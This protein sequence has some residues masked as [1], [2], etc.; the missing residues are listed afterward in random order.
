MKKTTSVLSI[1][2]A[3]LMVFSVTSAAADALTLSS[4]TAGS[5]D[6]LATENPQI[7]ASDSIV[8]TFSNNVTDDSVIGNNI[9]KINVKD[10]DGNKLSTVSVSA[11]TDK[12]QLAVS[13]GE[14][15]KGSY[16]LTVAKGIKAKNGSELADKTEIKFTV[17]KGSGDGS[18]G[19]NN[20]LSFV[21]A[22][23]NDKELKGAELAGNEIIVIEFDRGMKTYEEDNAKAIGIYKADN[24]K[25]DYT[26]LPV[27]KDQ[28]ETK[29]LVK[30]QLN[31]L[32]SG[33]YTLKIGADVK[34]NNG[35]T[36][37]E[38]VTVAFTVKAAE[39]SLLDTIIEYLK[40]AVEFVRN[41]ITQVVALF[42]SAQ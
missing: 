42:K 1:I 14:I 25:A 9:G 10:S 20:P 28:E 33:E 7:G 30:I 6:L 39:K 41:I 34:A 36:L 35:N 24:T 26:V 29:R 15:S 8:I 21:S 12:T 5:V 4:V 22:K 40:I 27:D 32:E 13:L 31:G 17:G 11:G 38:D 2:L 37:G 23:A 18:G 3:L 16:T 19:G